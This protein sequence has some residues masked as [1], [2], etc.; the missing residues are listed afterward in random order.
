MSFLSINETRVREGN[1]LAILRNLLP[2]R[3]SVTNYTHHPGGRI[4][5]FWDLNILTVQV[6]QRS[7]QII[8]VQATII[9]KQ[10]VLGIS[11]IYGHNTQ[12]PRRDLWNSLR[13]ISSTI[14]S[15]PWLVVGDFNM[16]RHPTE[17]IGGATEWPYYLEDLNE[18]CQDSLLEDLR[19]TGRLHT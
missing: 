19:F 6:V 5:I 10:L 11:C 12:V 16:I 8:H 14:L 2:G 17:C 7:E 15:T 18:C 9:Q 1:N 13:L 4:W 3:A